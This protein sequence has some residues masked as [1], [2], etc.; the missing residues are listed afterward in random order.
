LI[1]VS[2]ASSVALGPTDPPTLDPSACLR[3]KKTRK[4]MGT[5]DDLAVLAA[6]GALGQAGLTA[7]ALGERAGLF[8]VV[9]YIPFNREDIDPV[10]AD[11]LIDER[12][13]MA[14]F[15]SGGFQ[16]AHPL[17]TFRCL[18][19]MPA[20]H[21]SAN[22]NVQGPYFVSYPGIGQV[23]TALEEA[24][25]ELAAGRIDVAV[26]FGVAHQRNFLV[27]HHFSRIEPPV[28]EGTL[29]DAAA[30]IVLESAEHVARRGG[31]AR[32][33]L[34]ELSQRYTPHSAISEQTPQREQ[35]SGA[36]LPEGAR[37]PASLFALLADALD[38]GDASEL[39]H[40]VDTRDHVSAQS[41]W[42]VLA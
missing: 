5:Q 19:N 10:L 18:P 29:W 22:F 15:S 40:T 33:E 27:Q 37:G 25:V 39:V 24:C 42:R 20:F 9:G 35:A 12:F 6:A 36:R 14:R 17:L 31:R 7:D 41:R 30:C 26:A 13:S 32:A 4:F 28:A 21:V 3:S 11:S 38:T 1:V 23:Y 8:A 2:G 34:V 16:R